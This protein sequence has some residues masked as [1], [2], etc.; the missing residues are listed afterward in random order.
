MNPHGGNIYDF[1]SCCD[2]VDF[3][4]NINP[5][6]PPAWAMSAA[7]SSLSFVSRYPDVNQIEIR[8]AF[9]NWLGVARDSLVF[10]NGASELIRAVIHAIRPTRVITVEPTFADYAE[11]AA[12]LGVRTVGIRT[13]HAENFAFPMGEIKNI[14]SEGDM[15]VACQPNNPT[16]R[17]WS[18]DELRELLEFAESRG[19]WVMADEC[20]LNLTHPRVFSCIPFA[21]RRAIVLRAIT[22]DFSAPGLRIGF[23]IAEPSIARRVRDKMQAWPLNCVGEAYAIACASSPEP[24]L[25]DSAKKIAVE[26]ARIVRGLASL[27]HHPYQSSVN[28]M[29]VRSARLPASKLYEALLDKNILIR[30]CANFPGLDDRHFRIA[31]RKPEDNDAFLCALADL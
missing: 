26:R 12:R 2:I 5:Y 16:G 22:K 7:E 18:E 23:A 30:R 19:G 17:V 25:S 13:F 11:C 3:S 10:G 9:S 20:F 1:A 4:S 31:V 15:F 14:F 6:G 8:D 28:F 21:N 29:L 24:F 27:G